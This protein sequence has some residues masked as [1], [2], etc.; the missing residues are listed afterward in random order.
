MKISSVNWIGSQALVRS[1]PIGIAT[2][3]RLTSASKRDY[4]NYQKMLSH[5]ATREGNR[6]ISIYVNFDITTNI[7]I[8]KA[9]LLSALNLES[10]F[11]PTSPVGLLENL[12]NLSRSQFVLSPPGA[13][14]DCFRTWEAIYL[15]AIPIV[16][17]SHWPFGH[18]DLP[19]IAIDSYSDIENVI[20]N[21][22]RDFR[23]SHTP[24]ENCFPFS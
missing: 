8:R 14:P 12:S 3:D 10:A 9:A 20:R 2:I 5:S 18:L 19:V 23:F 16:L 21:H 1:L 7:S 17:K 4:A 15:G 6:E 11:L 13:G 24:L 22:R